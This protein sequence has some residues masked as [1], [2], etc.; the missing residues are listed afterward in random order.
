[1]KT[2]SLPTTERLYLRDSVNE[3]FASGRGFIVYPYRVIYRVLPETEKVPARVSIMTIAP[4]KKFKHAVDRN[5]V[6]RLTRE[7]YRLNKVPLHEALAQQGRKMHVAFL[8]LDNKF[9]SFEETQD[10][11]QQIIRRLIEPHK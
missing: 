2:F 3:L 4:K 5:H 1:M 9:L 11:M 10:K 8:Y 6:K 7:A